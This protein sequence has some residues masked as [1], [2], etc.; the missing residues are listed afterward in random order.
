MP[1]SQSPGQN[2]KAH[3][4]LS[5]SV[6]SC[7]SVFKWPTVSSVFHG[8]AH[9]HLNNHHGV[10]LGWGGGGKKKKYVLHSNSDANI[11]LLLRS[12]FN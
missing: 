4:C 8:I 11:V 3:L 12:I 1:D 2:T 6:I 10:G 9:R 5:A 7:K